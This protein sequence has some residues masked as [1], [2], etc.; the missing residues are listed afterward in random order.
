MTLRELP[1]RY[2]KDGAKTGYSL[3]EREVGQFPKP[4]SHVMLEPRIGRKMRTGLVMLPGIL[5]R[6]KAHSIFGN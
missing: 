4:D 1:G 3:P 2:M 5:C 6:W